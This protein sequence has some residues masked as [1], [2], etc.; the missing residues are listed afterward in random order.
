MGKGGHGFARS[1]LLVAC[2]ADVIPVETKIE[3]FLSFESVIGSQ[4]P[5]I[6]QREL[7]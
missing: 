4:A 7:I 2:N 6:S 1:V 3:K 5:I